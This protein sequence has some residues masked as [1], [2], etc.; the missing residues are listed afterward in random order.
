MP[1][2]PML[3]YPPSASALHVL[4][5]Y[6]SQEKNGCRRGGGGLRVFLTADPCRSGSATLAK[7]IYSLAC[8]AK[9]VYSLASCEKS[10]YFLACCA[11][12]SYVFPCMLCNIFIFPCLLCEIFTYSILF[13]C[14][15]TYFFFKFNFKTII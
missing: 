13:P 12:S 1:P 4:S 10:I 11:R 9:S 6:S 2:H 3:C 8:C 7:S 14:R 15:K 5:F